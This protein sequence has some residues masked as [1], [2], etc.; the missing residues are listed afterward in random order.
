MKPHILF[1]CN[2]V[3]TVSGSFPDIR[4]TI[5]NYSRWSAIVKSKSK[6]PKGT[7][8]TPPPPHGFQ[9]PASE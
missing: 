9:R 2:G 7:S 5:V 1:Y 8:T 4:D 6:T 3:A